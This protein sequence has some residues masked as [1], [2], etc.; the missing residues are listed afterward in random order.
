M[1]E[2]IVKL[3]GPCIVVGAGFYVLDNPDV[4]RLLMEVNLEFVF[5]I[6]ALNVLIFLTN[7]LI[8]KALLQIF[9]VSITVKDSFGVSVVASIGN[10]LTCLGGGTMGKAFYL[11]RKYALCY[12]SFISSISVT[13]LINLFLSC[14]AGACAIWAIGFTSSLLLRIILGLFLLISLFLCIIFFFPY[15]PRRYKNRIFN[16]LADVIKGWNLIKRNRSLLMKISLLLLINYLISTAE[17]MLSYKA[18]S[19]DVSISQA[20]LIVSIYLFAGMIKILPA[21]FGVYEGSIALSSQLLGIGFGQG[22]LAAGLSSVMATIM[23]FS[24]GGMFGPQLLKSQ[25]KIIS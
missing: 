9:D 3:V 14:I 24:V 8:L 1:R 17:I 12:S 22:L 4:Y 6:A 25:I 2:S 10:C 11:K 19:I 7:A 16:L 20:L 18:F 13:S 5:V 23:I 15:E 21:N